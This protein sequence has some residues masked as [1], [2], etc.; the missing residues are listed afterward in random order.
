VY[1][2]WFQLENLQGVPSEW[3]KVGEWKI[4]DNVICGGDVVSF[5]AVKASEK[6]RLK[7]NL[8]LFSYMLPI[9]VG[10]SG[11]YTNMNDSSNAVSK[12]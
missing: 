5:Y 2:T 11:L 8:R 3:I 1:D 6:E 10:Q 4:N 12:P 9:N 7:H